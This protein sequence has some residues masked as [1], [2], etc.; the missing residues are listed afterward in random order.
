M[1]YA[2][3]QPNFSG[4]Y[5]TGAIHRNA[6]S[7]PPLPVGLVRQEMVDHSAYE[8]QERLTKEKQEEERLR[9]RKVLREIRD[10]GGVLV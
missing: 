10:R 9:V 4:F 7:D 1:K 2:A 5:S 6:P 3:L 8:E